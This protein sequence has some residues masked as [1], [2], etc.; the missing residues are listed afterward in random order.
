MSDVLTQQAP[1]AF[2]L[3][4][5]APLQLPT[6]EQAKQT[7]VPVKPELRSELDAK[8]VSSVED[9]VARVSAADLHSDDFRNMLDRA[10]AAGRKEITDTSTFISNNPLLRQTTFKDYD[11]TDGAK[12]LRELSV[13]LAKANPKG[14][15]LLG[16][17]KVMGIA[18]PFGSKLRSYMDDFKPVGER[19]NELI[20]VLESEED[21]Q[22]R[23][24]AS[25]DIVEGQLFEKLQ[26]L[27]RATEYLGLLDQRLETESSALQTLNPEKSKAVREEV[28][29][30]VRGN[31]SDVTQQK[32]LTVAAIGQIRQLRHTGRMTL[33]GTNR[34]RTLGMDALA[35]AQTMAIATYNQKKR[36]D[37]NRQAQQVVN[38]MVAG[39]G[40]AVLEHT[41]LVIEFES[42]PLL[43]IQAIESGVDKT[44]EAIN[45]LNNYRST[46]VD[47]MKADNVKLNALY[48]KAKTG[49]RI[50]DKPVAAEYGDVF[51]I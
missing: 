51:S 35:I 10:F 43:G 3:E 38:D 25:Y 44:L 17:V 12:A 49:M 14:K 8:I 19:I 15:D 9:F 24:I 34:V 23:E 13:L 26:R 20:Q 18:M 4:P 21:A 27:D 46:A 31:L 45:L 50:L 22:R 39:V 33:R 48:D 2:V 6:V 30:Y 16:P 40:D 47:T 28:L 5:P 37:L 32:L 41:K 42:N 1:A 7:I 29:F 11:D 36:M